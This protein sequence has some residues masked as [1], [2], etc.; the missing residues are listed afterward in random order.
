MS[1]QIS[2][3]SFSPSEPLPTSDPPPTLWGPHK[4]LVIWSR[5]S[6]GNFSLVA[7]ASICFDKAWDIRRGKIGKLGWFLMETKTLR[8]IW[9]FRKKLEKDMVVSDGK[10]DYLGQKNMKK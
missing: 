5:S 4:E 9:C 7:I 3:N 6:S 10:K 8:K 1:P 2:K